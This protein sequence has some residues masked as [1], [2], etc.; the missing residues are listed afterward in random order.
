MHQ[1]CKWYQLYQKNK[2]LVM[3]KSNHVSNNML[4]SQLKH[5]RKIN[6]CGHHIYIYIYIKQWYHKI[7]TRNHTYKEQAVS[8]QDITKPPRYRCAQQLTS[9]TSLV[10]EQ[11]WIQ[12]AYLSLGLPSVL[13]SSRI[14][15]LNVNLGY[16]LRTQL[17]YLPLYDTQRSFL[18]GKI[19]SQSNIT[20]GH[21][22]NLN[23]TL[24]WLLERT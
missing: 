2:T 5:M 20:D 1:S 3:K 8:I 9:L 13:P 24:C 21:D 17:S 14:I 7:H 6:S 23:L 22:R 4:I 12:A 15:P 19:L 11:I 16:Q 18:I 10:L